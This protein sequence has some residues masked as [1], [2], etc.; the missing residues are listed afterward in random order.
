ML[1]TAS[2]K[3]AVVAA[4][5]A[6]A[7]GLTL[8]L[9]ASG[10]AAAA[11]PPRT[12]TAADTV[13]TDPNGRHT[14]AEIHR[15]LASFYGHHG[16]GAWAREHQVSDYLKDR[17]AHTE[18]YDLLLCAQNTPREI[19]IGKVT[20]AQSAAVGWA[21][22]TTLWDGGQ[23]SSFTAYVGLESRPIVLQD[24]DCGQ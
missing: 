16:P 18:G 13:R 8:T 22:V 14:A 2:R 4:A 19:T 7:L 11:A 1:R 3:T 10:P 9:A 21:T 6:A 15:F 12:A 23:R 20:T 24:V 17:A 5:G